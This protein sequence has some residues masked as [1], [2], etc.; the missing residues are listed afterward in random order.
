MTV[1]LSVKFIEFYF[2]WLG[3]LRNDRVI[4]R[5]SCVVKSRFNMH[6]VK[7]IFSPVKMV[8]T[9][10]SLQND[11]SIDMHKFRVSFTIAVWHLVKLLME[12]Q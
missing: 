2:T 1:Y 9:S 3:I 8:K 6:D 5:G 11:S 10:H 12:I 7:L 4:I